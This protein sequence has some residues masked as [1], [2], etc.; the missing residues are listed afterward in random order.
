[1]TTPVD[2]PAPHPGWTKVVE[3]LGTVY[4]ELAPQ[5]RLAWAVPAQTETLDADAYFSL[6]HAYSEH[7]ER[8][9]RDWPRL[10]G[11]I[12][13]AVGEVDDPRAPC[14]PLDDACDVAA[15]HLRASAQWAERLSRIA[16]P[17]ANSS[18]P[19]AA[20]RRILETFFVQ[21]APGFAD[22]RAAAQ[23][24]GPPPQA[25]RWVDVRGLIRQAS[26]ADCAQFERGLAGL[27]AHTEESSGCRGLLV[28]GA[29][30]LLV[31]FGLATCAPGK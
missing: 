1:M 22:M 4:A 12:G 28:C 19:D 9:A 16:Q 23:G 24:V 14:P 29:V 30:V 20:N 8:L 25:A 6:K 10:M 27:A 17:L 26:D 5:V 21:I 18:P 11:E 15:A 3:R 13:E 31:V 7:L 2:L